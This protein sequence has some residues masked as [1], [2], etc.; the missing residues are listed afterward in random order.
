MH[1]SEE[2]PHLHQVLLA[3][4]RYS[5]A[6]GLQPLALLKQFTA[7]RLMTHRPKGMHH[8]VK[9]WVT[10]AEHDTHVSH[11]SLDAVLNGIERAAEVLNILQLGHPLPIV[12]EEAG[13]NLLD[14]DFQP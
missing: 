7:G 1:R 8:Y 5:F 9:P 11:L 4:L 12:P 3:L 14:E 2:G 10:E 6:L 13:R